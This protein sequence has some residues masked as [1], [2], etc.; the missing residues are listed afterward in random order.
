MEEK[1][2]YVWSEN[3]IK[4]FTRFPKITRVEV[5][6][7]SGRKYVNWDCKDVSLSIQDNDRTLKV[8][9]GPKA[10]EVKESN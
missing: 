1:N 7:E 3:Q 9:I 6:E 5:I 10:K 8:F 4:E 2:G